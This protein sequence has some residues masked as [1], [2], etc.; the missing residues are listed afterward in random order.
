MRPEIKYDTFI[1]YRG[2]SV[3]NGISEKIASQIYKA[4]K[5][6]PDFGR[7]FF[8]P[9][10]EVGNYNFIDDA[11][12]IISEVK[13]FIVVLC[14]DFFD[15]FRTA[16]GAPNVK[17]SA[18]Y[19]ELLAAFA[20]KSLTFVPVFALGYYWSD[21]NKATVNGLYADK[22]DTDRLF[23]MTG[24]HLPDGVF[25]PRHVK[26]LINDGE[27]NTVEEKPSDRNTLIKYLNYCIGTVL[28]E[29]TLILLEDMTS[30]EQSNNVT[31]YTTDVY[32][33]MRA[34]NEN[35]NVMLMP[36]RF[37]DEFEKQK[38]VCKLENEGFCYWKLD[39]GSDSEYGE[40][41]SVCSVCFGAILSYNFL[42]HD[43]AR[44]GGIMSREEMEV[45][46]GYV[47]KVVS[48]ALNLLVALRSPI[49]KTWPSNWE[50]IARNGLINAQFVEGTINQ[51]TLSLSTFLVCDFLPSVKGRAIDGIPVGE[52]DVFKQR[53]R[54]LSE[55]INKLIA[56]RI[57]TAKRRWSRSQ[58]GWGY[59]P[60]S[61]RLRPLPTSF[62]FDVLTKFSNVISEWLPVFSEYDK[63]FYTELADMT[64]RIREI[65]SE[66]ILTFSEHKK[67][68]GSFSMQGNPEAPSSVTHTAKVLKTL[69]AYDPPKEDEATVDKVR[70]ITEGAVNCLMSYAPHY[71]VNG[72]GDEEIFENFK[73]SDA[74]DSKG[75][76]YENSGE[77]LYVDALAKAAEKAY[78]SGNKERARE[79]FDRARAVFDRFASEDE[80]FVVIDGESGDDVL[81][82][83][84]RNPNLRYPIFRLYFYRM[85]V[86]DLL[87]YMDADGGAE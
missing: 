76:S 66:V 71:V 80:G 5:D 47:R 39:L 69:L 13:R 54:Y 60:N 62:G 84:G 45:A 3:S 4:I 26:K 81:M 53:Y 74:E 85:S 23:H 68:D 57:V 28:S 56:C 15:G 12:P 72:L 75:E 65:L 30:R 42:K 58:S 17:E 67:A 35:R 16:D 52:R 20:N 9:A 24:L 8:A 86:D 55:S 37:I 78:K 25:S 33:F 51:T 73:Y 70:A 41:I 44:M 22:F 14:P 36:K 82:V 63:D 61:K 18:T 43:L 2:R 7:V 50:F 40:S 34:C 38:E 11:D 21:A 79:L 87:K 83:G 1:C 59:M 46:E 10:P 6:N 77:L 29:D 31:G 27:N 64:E 49:E 48:G 19:N 32:E